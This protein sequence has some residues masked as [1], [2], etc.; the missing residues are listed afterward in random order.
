M[1]VT[2]EFTTTHAK[3]HFS[4]DRAETVNFVA[5]IDRKNMI[6]L[7]ELQDDI[8]EV[9]YGR[10]SRT[11]GLSIATRPRNC[12]TYSVHNIEI[13]E[14]LWTDEMVAVEDV[15]IETERKGFFKTKRKIPDDFEPDPDI[16][17]KHEWEAYNE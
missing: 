4:E 1:Q 10:I 7:Y 16:W 9:Y 13:I 2:K 12:V 6:N 8:W 14:P 15:P 5:R 17:E 3:V 11:A